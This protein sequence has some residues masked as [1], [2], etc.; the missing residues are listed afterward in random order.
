MKTY[1]KIYRTAIM[2]GRGDTRTEAAQA[3]ALAETLT[4]GA[5]GG[6]ISAP[7]VAALEATWAAIRERHPEIPRGGDRARRR[8]DRAAGGGLKLG[9]VSIFGRR[10]HALGRPTCR[11]TPPRS[12]AVA[13][14]L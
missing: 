11:T 7:R 2:A 13:V 5:A 4:P 6:P 10:G 14:P 3:A 12:R 1:Q 9:H 8:L